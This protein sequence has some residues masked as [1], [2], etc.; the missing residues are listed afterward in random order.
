MVKRKQYKYTGVLAKPIHVP[1]YLASAL[2][3]D[4]AEL[5]ERAKAEYMGQHLDRMVALAKDCGVEFRDPIEWWKIALALAERHVPG[6]SYADDGPRARGRPK[7]KAGSDLS[8]IIAMTKLMVA[9]GLSIR[10]A[11]AFVAKQRKKGESA[12]ALERRYRRFE[13]RTRDVD[14]RQEI[15][16]AFLPR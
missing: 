6:F 8:L 1:L 9:K 15:R 13:E 14:V 11:A 10:S 7:W 16:N 12:A 3:P 5:R 2:N 4:D